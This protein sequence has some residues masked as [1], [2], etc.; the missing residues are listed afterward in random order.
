MTE[1]PIV[2]DSK[3][4]VRATVPGVQIPLSPRFEFHTNPCEIFF[5]HSPPPRSTNS[6]EG[7][8]HFTRFAFSFRILHAR[9]N[10]EEKNTC[11]PFRGKRQSTKNSSA[12]RPPLETHTKSAKIRLLFFSGFCIQ[13]GAGKIHYIGF[14][15]I[16]FNYVE[17]FVFGESQF[18]RRISCFGIPC[19]F[20][21]I[22]KIYLN[23]NGFGV[24]QIQIR[25]T[26]IYA[27]KNGRRKKIQRNLG[28]EAMNL[29]SRTR[30]SPTIPIT[31]GFHSRSSV[32]IINIKKCKKAR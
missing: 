10:N 19:R 17:Q 23:G 3:S 8:I 7:S 32:F 16:L 21:N 9:P 28:I 29:K 31:K 26:L 25:N 13:A 27:V 6:S 22:V 15:G 5:A 14:V 4:G 30:K 20:C 12:T 24:L 1:W 11:Q 18:I 2:P